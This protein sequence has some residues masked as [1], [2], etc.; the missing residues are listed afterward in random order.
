M[1]IFIV[2]LVFIIVLIM[3]YFNDWFLGIFF[4]LD[5][6]FFQGVGVSIWSREDVFEMFIGYREGLGAV[7][8]GDDFYFFVFFD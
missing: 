2:I 5:R 4:L 8:V 1:G 3:L 7:K 6:E